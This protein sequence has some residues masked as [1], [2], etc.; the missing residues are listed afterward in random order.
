M[1]KFKGSSGNLTQVEGPKTSLDT[2]EP[3]APYIIGRELNLRK[4]PGRQWESNPQ[5]SEQLRSDDKD[6]RL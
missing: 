3:T 1:I 4:L 5:L 6:W 2:N